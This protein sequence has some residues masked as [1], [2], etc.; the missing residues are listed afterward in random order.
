[1]RLP[2][3]MPQGVLFPFPS[4]FCEDAL[5]G[6]HQP[7]AHSP[8][9]PSPHCTLTCSHATPSGWLCRSDGLHCARM[10]AMLHIT[11]MMFSPFC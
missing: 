9:V 1:M 7:A 8:G 6:S 4:V 10:T 5:H 11:M 3:S 2:Q